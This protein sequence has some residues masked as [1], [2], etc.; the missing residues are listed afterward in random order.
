MGTFGVYRL[1]HLSPFGGSNRIRTDALSKC[2][3]G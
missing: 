1:K 2:Q 3:F